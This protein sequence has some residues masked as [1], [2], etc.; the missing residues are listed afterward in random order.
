MSLTKDEYIEII[1]LAGLGSCHKVVMDFNMQHD[2][3]ITND[4]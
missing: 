1:V 3:H 2:K 4:P